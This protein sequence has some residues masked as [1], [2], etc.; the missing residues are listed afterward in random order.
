MKEK[1]ITKKHMIVFLCVI[2]MLCAGGIFARNFFHK[3]QQETK[4]EFDAYLYEILSYNIE[5]F[6]DDYLA[7]YQEPDFREMIAKRQTDRPVEVF[8]IYG[9][10]NMYYGDYEKAF[11]YF[12]KTKAYFSDNTNTEIKART[13][14]EMFCIYGFRQEYEKADTYA[15]FFEEALEQAEDPYFKVAMYNWYGLKLIDFPGGIEKAIE[16]MEKNYELAKE[17][18]YP[19]LASIAYTISDLYTSADN[20]VQTMRYKLESLYQAD[21]IG[22]NYSRLQVIANLGIDYMIDGYYEKALEYLSEALEIEVEDP[23]YQTFMRAYISVNMASAYLEQEQIEKAEEYLTK[24]EEYVS[25]EDYLKNED[26]VTYTKLMRAEFLAYLGHYDE[27]L[28]MIDECLEVYNQSLNFSYSAFDI[29][30]YRQYAEIS[31]KQGRYDD[32]T[33]YYEKVQSMCEERGYNYQDVYLKGFYLIYKETG[34]HEKAYELAEQLYAN[35]EEEYHELMEQQ[36][37]YMFEQ[38]ESQKKDVRIS[39]LEAKTQNLIVAIVFFVVLGTVV[40]V[41]TVI[42]YRQN[43]EIKRLNRKFK[44]QSELDGLTGLNNRRSLNEYVSKNWDKIS[45]EEGIIS[46]AMIDVDFFKTYNDY[47]GHLKGDDALVSLTEVLKKHTPQNDFVARYGGEEFAIIMPGTSRDEAYE[48]LSVM[49]KELEALHLVHEKS[50]ISDH[51]T[52]SAGIYTT[53]ERITYQ[54]AFIKADEALYQA[55]LERNKIIALEN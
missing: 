48:L 49:R 38:Y 34:D 3:Q 37:D 54:N 19:D 44:E 35:L 27:A 7:P 15:A 25:Q 41:F 55:K 39:E 31:Y 36:A 4:D 50:T 9:F 17:L 13:Y 28:E 16:I 26:D 47:Y 53:K 12:T 32:A 14:Y 11:Q 2:C 5:S 45:T 21:H 46:V 33:S 18:D 29:E 43:K 51:V 30:I 40:L 23:E 52:F 6:T 24:A 8:F 10:E 20:S 1:K 22:D 42:T